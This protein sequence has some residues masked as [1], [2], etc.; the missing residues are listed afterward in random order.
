MGRPYRIYKP[1]ASKEKVMAKYE[2][3]ADI[4]K[5]DWKEDLL[6]AIPDQTKLNEI[7]DLANQEYANAGAP[8][9]WVSNQKL[10]FKTVVYADWKENVENGVENWASGIKGKGKKKIGFQYI[11]NKHLVD[12]CRSKELTH[13]ASADD[14]H[15]R[16]TFTI[17]S[18]EYG[19]KILELKLA[20]L[21][22]IITEDDYNTQVANIK[23]E[24]S[25]KLQTVL[26]FDSTTADT[27]A[28]ELQASA[29]AGAQDMYTSVTGS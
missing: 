27:L 21:F 26:G 18:M 10:G 2:E 15:K 23:S 24:Y 3:I 4:R 1:T 14:Y 22:D 9:T 12:F 8:S 28:D 20:E 11:G 13:L 17:F 7:F 6:S 5:D 29:E 19:R 16:S 25:T